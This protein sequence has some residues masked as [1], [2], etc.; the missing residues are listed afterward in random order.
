MGSPR[1]IMRLTVSDIRPEPGNVSLIEL[2]HPREPHLPPFEP[3]AHVDVHLPDKK[4]RQYSLCGDLTDLS[5]YTIAVKREEPGR[6]G[7]AWIHDNIAIGAELR[8]SAPRNHFPLAESDGPV[9]LLAGGIGITPLLAMARVLQQQGKPFELHYFTKSRRLAPLLFMIER[10]LAPENV[11]LHFDDDR[12]TRQDIE[13]LLS[14]RPA[15]TQLYYCGPPGFMAAIDRAASGWPAG[16]VHFEAFEPPATDGAPPEPFTIELRS[17]TVVTVGA[18]TS[19]L[20]AL[21][22]AGVPLLASCENGVCGTCECGYLEGHP[23]HRDAVLS[24][25]AKAHRFIPCVSRAAGRLKLDL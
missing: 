24:K 22:A 11:R 17:G 10:D 19:A 14:K 18:D 13:A 16:T 9:L 20:A 23:I 3:G 2:R 1:I 12:G 25:D 5:R 21:R 6:G 15:G 8:V 7:S 4:V